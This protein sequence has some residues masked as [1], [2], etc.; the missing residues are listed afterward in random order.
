MSLI[1]NFFVIFIVL[2]FFSVASANTSSMTLFD[3]FPS[4][5]ELPGGSSAWIIS[6]VKEDKH[7]KCSVYTNTYTYY[8]DKGSVFLGI[9]RKN[10]YMVSVRVFSCDNFLLA[11]EKY[12]S[13]LA[14]EEKFDT[15]K[16]QAAA[17]FGERGVLTA[18]P[19]KPGTRE[20]DFYLTYIFRSFVV[21]VYSEDG[22]SQMD[23]AGEV[24]KRLRKYLSSMGLS[25]FM[26]K[27]NLQV[28]HDKMKDYT[29]S[30][31]FTGDNITAVVIDGVVY[32]KLNKPVSGAEITAKETGHSTVTDDDGTYTLNVEAG[33]G[34]T[35]HINRVIF[36]DDYLDD[37]E[38]VS[39]GVYPLELYKGGDKQSSYILNMLI[40]DGKIIGTAYNLD[41]SGSYPING[42]IENDKISFN[43]NC[44][45]KGAAFKCSRVFNGFLSDYSIINGTWSG[46]G[47]KGV[48]DINKEKFAIVKETPYL[49]DVGINLFPVKISGSSIVKSDV[50]NMTV[51]SGEEYSFIKLN[52]DKNTAN[53]IYFKDGSIVLDIIEN[54]SS[55]KSEIIIYS[56]ADKDGQIVLKKL[57]S[58]ASVDKGQTG[59][60]VIDISSQI[61][62][63]S[64]SG[65]LIGIESDNNVYMTFSNDVGFEARYYADRQSY[66]SAETLSAKVLSF[67]GD[68]FA[69]NSNVLRPDG[70][71]DIVLE[72]EINAPNR[73]LELIEVTVQGDSSI[74]R[75]NTNHFDIYPAVAVVDGNGKILNNTN[76]AIQTKL[77]N[78]VETLNLHL[79]KGSL[80]T[81]TIKS[82][83]VK[84]VIDGKVYD[85][86]IEK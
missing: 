51:S 65:Y 17:A 24:E 67:E 66:K 60:I 32:D 3:V 9:E 31:S 48:W 35:L 29:T 5:G 33:E 58:A 54:K 28:K 47:G 40:T 10:T 1:R 57:S 50:E 75:W 59:R 70:E 15:P 56:V 22:F 61:R 37:G 41:G 2:C 46:T 23:M 4:S 81:D 26:N 38:F 52:T 27:I 83:S 76:G 21:Q 45:P 30:V 16:Q 86:V 20:A 77:P 44:T 36:M 18:I 12:S 85:Y 78:G 53:S 64:A 71:K 68:D 6:G 25:Y 74:R 13:L 84:V 62:V 63:P 69:G 7:D 72:V 79:F 39:S 34:N 49:R 14:A 82:F 43:L 11:A 8:A 19:T 42:N 80:N 73:L 55:S